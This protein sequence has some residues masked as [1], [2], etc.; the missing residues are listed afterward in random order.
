MS[1]LSTFVVLQPKTMGL[2]QTGGCVRSKMGLLFPPQSTFLSYY[3]AFLVVSLFPQDAQWF[4][5]L[6]H[7]SFSYIQ[8][9]F[10]ALHVKFTQIFGRL[11]GKGVSPSH[12]KVTLRL[13]ALHIAV[14]GKV[15]ALAL[16]RRVSESSVA[17]RRCGL[18][19]HC[20]Q[21]QHRS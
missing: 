8:R 21:Y 2:C 12:E 9:L 5:F 6:T 14:D 11:R 19:R 3:V 18:P 15:A 20:H 13:K 1:L 10:Y 7:R 16:Q 4:P 17:E